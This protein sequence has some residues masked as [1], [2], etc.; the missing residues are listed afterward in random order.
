MAVTAGKFCVWI[1][2]GSRAY[3]DPEDVPKQYV[4]SSQELL[5]AFL[6]GVDE[7]V[8]YLDHRCFESEKTATKFIAAKREEE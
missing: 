3:L 6:Q 4:F 7:A 2:W 1:V 5:D 8:G